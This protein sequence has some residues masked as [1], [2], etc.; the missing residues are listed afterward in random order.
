M[1]FLKWNPKPSKLQELLT[2]L[3]IDR[4]IVV[5]SEEEFSNWRGI[6]MMILT[7]LT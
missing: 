3:V 2:H 7:M 6:G 4:A 5:P 1:E